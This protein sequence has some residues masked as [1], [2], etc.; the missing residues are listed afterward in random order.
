VDTTQNRLKAIEL[1]KAP[2]HLVA[3][4]AA[5]ASNVDPSLVASASTSTSAIPAGISLAETSFDSA[6]LGSTSL[7]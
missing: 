4:F 5:R 1:G 7:A 6:L 2:S 3:E